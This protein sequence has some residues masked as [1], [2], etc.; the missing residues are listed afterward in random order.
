MKTKVI[1]NNISDLFEKELNDFL[2]TIPLYCIV[3]IKYSGNQTSNK[4]LV[5]YKEPDKMKRISTAH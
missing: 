5:L 2:A 3:D 1:S 4:A